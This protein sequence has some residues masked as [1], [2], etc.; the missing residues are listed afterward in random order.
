MEKPMKRTILLLCIVPVI[1]A[2][3]VRSA[4]KEPA[5]SLMY[6]INLSSDQK[7][8]S[9]P[10]RNFIGKALA[11]LVIADLSAIKGV[12]FIERNR[13][14]N[15]MSEI[16]LGM[17]GVINESTSPK[18]GQLLG[19]NYII[20]GTYLVSG[21]KL[22]VTYK[23]I[24]AESG[25]IM[26][27]GSVNGPASDISQVK[28]SLSGSISSSLKSVFPAIDITAIKPVVVQ[29]IDIAA[30]EGFGRALDLG[31][32][33]KLKEASDLMKTLLD[34][35]PKS[36]Q[37]KS[38]LNAFDRR[39][40]EYDAKRDE[41]LKKESQTVLTWNMFMKMSTAYLSSAKYS[42]LYE[43]CMKVRPSPPSIPEGYLAE[44][45]EMID[46]YIVTSLQGLK[47][48]PEL[49]KEGEGFLQKYPTS[50]YYQSIKLYMG[51]A[52]SIMREREKNRRTIAS[53]IAA[54]ENK[55]ADKG[56]SI[57]NYHAGLEYYSKQ[58]YP[59]AVERFK[60]IDFRELPK[61]GTNGDSILY[62]MFQCYY[63]IPDKKGGEKTYKA[64]ETFY[65][66][67]S[68]LNSMSSMM[69]FFPE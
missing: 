25:Q 7:I 35:N 39:L 24:Q 6:F 43:L 33:G 31:D 54:I 68:Y 61:V 41:L 42:K 2:T 55:F 1:F 51:Q 27:G 12:I 26:K 48:Y 22:V 4:D 66:E 23:I 67:S 57:I 58:F 45:G 10:S 53:D 15:V 28:T 37:F 21:N 29:H 19:A 64:I 20:D 63:N 8:N 30:V 44:P 52:A 14:E 32:Q 13:L 56:E 3:P 11:E 65:P 5:L 34:K 60:K 59:E 16:E 9:A 49:I 47:R 38:A 36:D 46:S 18:I 40:K 69:N 17:A 50:M 62:Y